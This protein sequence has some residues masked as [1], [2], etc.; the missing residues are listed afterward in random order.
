MSFLDHIRR[1]NANDLDGFLP[2][3]IGGARVGWVRPAVRDVLL[4]LGRTFEARAG[5]V[6]LAQR[7]E[8]F[9]DRSAA[10]FEATTAIA[11][12]G[13]APRT[14]SE[15]YGVR[16]HWG[17][18]PVAA[19]D[20]SV[21]A[22]FGFRAYG[23]HVNGW[24][25]NAAGEIELWI[26]RR[27]ADKSVEPG[28]LDNMVAGGQP[29]GLTL[30]ENLVKEAAEEA[31][32]PEALARTAIP[33]GCIAYTMETSEGLKPDMMFCYDLEVP[34]DFKP[35]NTDGETAEFLLMPAIDAGSRISSSDDFKFNVNLVI[36]DFL[37]RHGL[38]N[39]D[40]EPDYAA[41]VAGLHG[42]RDGGVRG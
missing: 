38:L 17:R 4:G 33:V 11:A 15:L 8:T 10:L 9:D 35:V 26:G 34:K 24:R 31:D 28:K 40:A 29:L 30:M 2:F 37:V 42:A 32:V 21:V 39:P 18:P 41:I 36:T 20:R 13:L 27:A 7:L 6:A 22:A 16:A 1:C 25:R 5:G 19:V 14:R 12:A 3:E 23:V